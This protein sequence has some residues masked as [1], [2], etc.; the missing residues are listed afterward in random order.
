M[1]AEP[2]NDVA[3]Q[4]SGVTMPSSRNWLASGLLCATVTALS[5]GIVKILAVQGVSPLVL[6]FVIGC[7]FAS[8][9]P[10]KIVN[11]TRIPACG[12]FLL[13]AGVALLGVQVSITAI[14]SLGLP[15]ILIAVAVAGGTIGFCV[16]IGRWLGIDKNLALLIGV[17]TGICG[18]SA[19]IA[20]SDVL[21]TRSG[22]AVYALV[23]ITVWVPS[24]W[25]YYRYCIPSLV[26]VSGSMVYFLA[27]C[28]M[29]WLRQSVLGFR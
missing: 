8:L 21:N 2:K 7:I 27:R 9:F 23:S 20:A 19:I 6:A 29:K 11:L 26:L 18:A 28:S 15:G 10:S 17:G 5:Y 24:V 25:L 14:I 12:K 1:A 13:R 4:P 22:E 16:I 3:S